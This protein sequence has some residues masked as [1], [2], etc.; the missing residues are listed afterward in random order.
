[1][2]VVGRC[3]GRALGGRRVREPA[4]GGGRAARRRRPHSQRHRRSSLVAR[5]AVRSILRAAAA[6][7]A[8]TPARAARPNTRV[9]APTLHVQSAKLSA[10][11]RLRDSAP[12]AFFRDGSYLHIVQG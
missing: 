9:S 3:G 11:D 10:S 12:A 2:G 1:M 8:P 6:P 7:L 4:P 5:V